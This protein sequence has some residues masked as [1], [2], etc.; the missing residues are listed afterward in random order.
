M[1]ESENSIKGPTPAKHDSGAADLEKVTDYAEEKEVLEENANLNNAI[2]L[3]SD[4]RKKEADQKAEKEKELANVKVIREE[5]ELLI[6]EFELNKNRAE[7]VLKENT[8]ELE[9]ALAFL[10]NS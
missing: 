3:I 7:R 4:K 5:V 1:D 10:I 2:N 9:P 6:F 8:G